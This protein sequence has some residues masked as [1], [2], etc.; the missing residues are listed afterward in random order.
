[1]KLKNKTSRRA[2]RKREKLNLE[3]ETLLD[4]IGANDLAENEFLNAIRN[5]DV[6]IVE[7]SF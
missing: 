1:M 6:E 3:I 5:G 7:D 2:E 4:Q